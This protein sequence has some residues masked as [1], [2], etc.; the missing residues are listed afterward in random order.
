MIILFSVNITKE[1]IGI[2]FIVSPKENANKK[3]F[4]NY[5]MKQDFSYYTKVLKKIKQCVCV[6]VYEIRFI[7]VRNKIF[8]KCIVL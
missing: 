6:C 1:G 7:Y 5:W 2:K 3:Q 8:K 4:H